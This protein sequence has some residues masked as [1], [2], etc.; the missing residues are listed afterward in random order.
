MF[1]KC[2]YC[3]E[4]EP[5]CG[6]ENGLLEG[7]IL[8]LIPGSFAKYRSPWQR[9]YKDNQKAEWEENMNYCDS[10][11]GK[12]SQVRLLDLIDASVFDFIIQ[13]G[14]RHHY[15]TRNERIVLIDNGKGFGQPFTDFLD[16]LAPL[17]QCCI[18]WDNHNSMIAVTGWYWNH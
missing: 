15:E 10:I 14:D 5:V 16:I 8:Q 7:A 9:T 12:L 18:F 6:D 13:N 2:F 4:S 1:G 3:K 17:Y 11:K